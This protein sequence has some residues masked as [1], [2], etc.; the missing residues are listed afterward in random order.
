[1]ETL[2]SSLRTERKWRN[3]QRVLPE[4]FELVVSAM[5]QQTQLIRQLQ[6][7]VDALERVE[8]TAARSE[9]AEE[10]L[11]TD[12]KRRM[13]RL[14]KEVSL[15][16][17]QQQTAI[18]DAKETAQSG[19]QRQEEAI[20]KA[21]LSL[22]HRCCKMEESLRQQIANAEQKVEEQHTRLEAK[23]GGQMAQLKTQQALNDDRMATMQRD[24]V[25]KMA[26]LERKL[27]T[28]EARRDAA[29]VP[30]L[31]EIKVATPEVP[32][33]EMVSEGGEHERA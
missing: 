17:E 29:V 9:L 3:V 30:V 28:D 12:T 25:Q 18:Q 11:L 32:N 6:S 16:L 1:M 33:R 15:S 27:A 23:V 19:A 4:T 5:A 14:R 26:A 10:R 24:M 13:S 31:E 20:A 22:K 8:S 7:R 21:E 2:E